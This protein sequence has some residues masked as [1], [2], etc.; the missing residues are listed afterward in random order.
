MSFPKQYSVICQFIRVHEKRATG[1]RIPMWFIETTRIV[2]KIEFPFATM[3][4]RFTLVGYLGIIEVS[5]YGC[6]ERV[7]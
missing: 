2:Y 6:G 5:I 4:F 1:P 3:I 7:V